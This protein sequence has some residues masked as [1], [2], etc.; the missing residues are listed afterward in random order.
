M[1]VSGKNRNATNKMTSASAPQCIMCVCAVGFTESIL[2]LAAFLSR[3]RVDAFKLARG[4]RVQI[5]QRLIHRR[6]D[7]PCCSQREPKARERS[8]KRVALAPTKQ[9]R[10]TVKRDR[11]NKHQ[12]KHA[13]GKRFE[14]MH[15]L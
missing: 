8:Q 4:L 6:Q 12:Q 7:E 14:R 2:I 15:A 1:S 11:W 9:L 13:Q 5:A 10:Q 3:A